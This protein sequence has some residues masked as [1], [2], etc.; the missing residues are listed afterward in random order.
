[1]KLNC[2]VEYALI[3]IWLLKIK[4]LTLS[5]IIIIIIRRLGIAVSIII[6]SFFVILTI[7]IEQLHLLLIKSIIH[8]I[9]SRIFY[10]HTKFTLRLCFSIVQNSLQFAPCWDNSISIILIHVTLAIYLILVNNI[11]MYLLWSIMVLKMIKF[12]N[13]YNLL[14]LIL[15]N[16]LLTN[17]YIFHNIFKNNKIFISIMILNFR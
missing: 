9:P 8:W 17:K 13:N 7:R 2:I 1:M 14:L 12:N 6:N 10:C 16:C 11:N 4:I 5:L 3:L 15:Y